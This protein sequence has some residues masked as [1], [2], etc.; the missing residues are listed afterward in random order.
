MLDVSRCRIPTMDEFRRIIDQLAELKANHLQLYTEHT[1]AYAG[2]EEVWRGWS[3]LT[4][5]EVG[6]LEGWCREKG[7]ELAANQN[8]FGHLHEW[9]GHERY[10]GLAETHGDWVFDVWPRRGPFS[11]CPTD[12]ASLRFVEDLLGQLLPCFT[13]PLVNIGCDETYDIAY[14]RSAA[15]VKRRGREAV[16]LDFVGKI[17]EVVRR[18]GKRPMFWADIALSHPACARDIPEDMVCLAWG[19]EPDAPFDRWCEQLRSA[20][21]EVW[22]CP[23]TSSWRSLTGR[24]T[25]RRGNIDAAAKAGEAGGATGFLVCD[26]GDTGHWQT[27]P[28]ALHGLADG[29]NAAWRGVGAPDPAAESLHVLGGA[30]GLAAWLDEF[31]DAD[32]ALREVCLPLS[33]PGV[34]G[35]LRNQSAIF[36]D[37]LRAWDADRSTGGLDRWEDAAR[38]VEACRALLPGA[39]DGAPV[40]VREDL[41]HAAGMASFAARRGV[42]R[43]TPGADASWVGPELAG[44]RERHRV[45]WL[46]GS[47]EGGLTR[48][49]GYFDQV[50]LPG[51]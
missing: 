17:A 21:R 51:A 3:P 26:W 1:F 44:L 41:E 37:L 50:G 29:L 27:W 48:S 8:C 32:R 9:F 4:P 38:R 31:G 14:G 13:S 33:R 30:P 15:E 7:I 25:E 10:A 36:I 12:P 23:G 35:R 28:I 34:E 18:H 24:T 2:H 46:R 11:L 22:V 43:R 39:A 40:P 42:C 47:R 49:I 19:Y 45:L 6:V 5:G 20:G 16:Y